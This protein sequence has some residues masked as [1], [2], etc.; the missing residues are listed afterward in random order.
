MIAMY[1]SKLKENL[2]TCLDKVTDGN[3]T[4]LIKRKD[5][6]NAV[7]LSEEMYNNILEN[8]YLTSDKANYDWLINSKKQYQEAKIATRKLIGEE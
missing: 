5:N 8:L 1:Y 6:R 2:K 3:K 4:I 7:I